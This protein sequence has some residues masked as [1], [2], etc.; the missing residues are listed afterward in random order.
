[1]SRDRAHPSSPTGLVGADHRTSYGVGRDA[2][3]LRARRAGA[4]R[5]RRGRRTTRARPT[6][7]PR[8][9][10]STQAIELRDELPQ[11]D[12]SVAIVLYTADEG[13]LA[14]QQLADL[15]DQASELGG[16]DG[17]D[18]VPS[19]DGTAALV[20][21]PVPATQRRRDQRRRGGPARA[22]VGRRARRRH[23]PGHRTGGHRGRPLRRLRRRRHATAAGDGGRG[24]AAAPA[25]LPQS[26]AVADPAHR[27]G[28]RRP[29]WPP[30]S[31]PRSWRSS[32]SPGT[33]RPRASCPCSSSVPAPTTPC[34]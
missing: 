13:E 27:R 11:D 20:V 24:R 17:A 1:M 26:G 30:S 31:R 29:R 5:P 28:R 33:A 34:C 7:L 4:R 8:G 9:A 32:A 19:K 6:R 21:V 15:K 16:P 12:S 2:G 18:L 22:G 14:D 10:D 23:R 25:H 3:V